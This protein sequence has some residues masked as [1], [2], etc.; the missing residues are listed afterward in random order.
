M[1]RASSVDASVVFSVVASVETNEAPPA[2]AADEQK[3]EATTGTVV[4]NLE[5]E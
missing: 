5:L 4:V 2:V 1:I 3:T